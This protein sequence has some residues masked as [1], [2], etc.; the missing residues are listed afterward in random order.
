MAKFGKKFV[1]C[2]FFKKHPKKTI[3]RLRHLK[4]FTTKN[5]ITYRLGNT[6]KT[7]YET[8]KGLSN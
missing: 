1:L 8:I 6:N 4:V 2:L 5:Q 7:A 3:T